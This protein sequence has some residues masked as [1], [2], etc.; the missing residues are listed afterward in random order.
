MRW[1]ILL[2]ILFIVVVGCQQQGIILE[3]DSSQ[4]L[5][6]GECCSDDNGNSVC[7][8]LELIDYQFE[9]ISIEKDTLKGEKFIINRTDLQIR[10][11]DTFYPLFDYNFI[12]PLALSLLG[13]IVLG[14]ACSFP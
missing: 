5:I 14:K 3:C 7:D 2:V 1:R 6:A 12:L 9:T 10:I 13:Q 8:D 11:N 4:I